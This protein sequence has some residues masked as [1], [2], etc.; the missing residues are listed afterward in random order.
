ML[1]FWKC[2][3]SGGGGV[4]GKRVGGSSVGSFKLYNNIC[5]HVWTLN[6]IQQQK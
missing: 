2:G 1:L 4:G 5:S 6:D 3:D